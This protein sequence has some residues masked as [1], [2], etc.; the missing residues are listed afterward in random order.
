MRSGRNKLNNDWFFYHGTVP[1]VSIGSDKTSNYRAVTL[2]HDFSL[3][4]PFSENAKSCGSGGYVETGVGWYKKTFTLDKEST[5]MKRTLLKFEGAYMLAEVWLNGKR[6]G[7]HVYGYT[8]FG[9]DITAAVN[10]MCNAAEENDINVINIVLDIKIDNSAQPNSRWYSG[11]G[12]TRSVWLYQLNETYLPPYGI[13]LKNQ[14]INDEKAA[15]TVETKIEGKAFTK[16]K[17]TLND[18]LGNEVVTNEV[19]VDGYGNAA[20]FPGS[21][22]LKPLNEL[23]EDEDGRKSEQEFSVPK[24]IL[25]SPENPYLYELVTGIYDPT[26]ELLDEVKTRIGF[27]TISFD[28]K[29]GF[30]L[31]N[32]R[33]KINGVCLHHDGG[34]MGAAVPKV[35]WR[36]RLLKLKAMGVNA[37]RTAHNPSDPG[38]L[39][40]CDELGFLVMEE[41]FDEWKWLKGKEGG[42]NTHQ[43]R[44]YSE[45]FNEYHEQDL[46]AMLYR[47]RNR[48]SIIIWSI[49]NEVPDQ[50]DPD[51]HMTARLLKGICKSLDPERPVTQGNDQIGAEPKQATQEFLRELD[52]IGY[53]YAGRWRDTAGTLYALDHAAHPEWTIIG[54]ENTSIAGSRGEYHFNDAELFDW[55]KKPYYSTPVT[56]GKLLKFT[57]TH[58]YVAGDFMWTGIDYLGEAH[59]PERSASSG[60]LDTCGFEKDGYYFYQSIWKRDEP[61]AY[62]LPHLNLD[63]EE[64]TVIPFLGYTNCDS[65]ELFVNGKSYGRKAMNYPAYGMSQIYGNF[66]KKRYLP[67]TDDLFLSW[68]VPY[69]SGSMRL[70]G[71]DEEGNEIIGYEIRSADKPERIKMRIYDDNGYSELDNDGGNYSLTADEGIFQVEIEITDVSGNF[72]PQAMDVLDIEVEGAAKLIGIDNGDPSSHQSF[73]GDR[74]AAYHGR[75]L[76]VLSTVCESGDCIIS[77]TANKEAPLYSY[78]AISH[79]SW[80]RV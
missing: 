36:R 73:R 57:M 59:W 7:R 10:E 71:Y 35:I 24:P 64:G 48:P 23:W 49:G 68:D 61:T 41:A 27:R 65:A 2:P 60:A 58:D 6:L 52:V 43:S 56:V 51:G 39:D 20:S 5:A 63:I 77:V 54:T 79:I 3:D 13:Y 72:C 15:F 19:T 21:E 37:I 12:I 46:K 40:L 11:S 50:T 47:D 34:C 75:A 70:V 30:I 80:S 44:G 55:R 38:L 8:P 26:G 67:S 53:N 45:W 66:E 1:P 42:A 16:L 22:Y 25:W 76:L 4:F 29:S 69:Q 31:N 74:I 33:Y 62:L 18:H 14:E 28:N 17:T 9:W 78:Q 32:Q